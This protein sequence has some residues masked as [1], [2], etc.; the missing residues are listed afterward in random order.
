MP[1]LLFEN[2]AMVGSFSDN[3]KSTI[4]IL[5]SLAAFLTGFT[6]C[7]FHN[8]IFC[9]SRITL[10]TDGKHFLTTV[11]YLVDYLQHYAGTPLANK[12]MHESQMCAHIL[13]DGPVMSLI[14]APVFL[15]LNKIPTPRDWLALAAGQSVLH[16]LS[17]TLVVLAAL[18]MTGSRFFALAAALLFGLYPPAVLQSGHFMSEIPVTTMLLA[19]VFS[20][21]QDKPAFFCRL[22]AGFTAG[23]IIL[24]K[25]ALLPGVVLVCLFVLAKSAP[26]Q[27]QPW[28][29]RLVLSRLAQIYPHLTGFALGLALIVIPWALMSFYSTGSF[30]PTAQRQPVYNVAT[31]WN[32]EAD[33]WGFNPRPP[34]TAMFFDR[35]SPLAVAAGIWISRPQE[36]ALLSISKVSRLASCPWN[37]FKGRAL[38]LDENAQILLHRLIIACA[39]FGAALYFF[40]GRRCLGSRQRLIIEM[41]IIVIVA[42]LSYLMVEC[43]PRYGFTAMPF[44]VLLAV[45]GIW[46]AL[47]LSL[48]DRGSRLSIVISVAGALAFTAFLLNAETLCRLFDRRAFKETAHVLGYMDRLQKIIDLS[49]VKTPE[50]VKSVF[51]MVDGDK[52]LDKC[53][54][55]INGTP[56]KDR[57]IP[58]MHFD[59]QHYNI[60]DQWRE[61][62][63]SMRVSVDDFRQWRAVAI[64]PALI[65][66]HGPNRIVLTN[67]AGNATVYGDRLRTRY[68]LS[69]DYCNYG[70]LSASPLSANAESRYTDPVLT[71]ADRQ[72]SFII[73]ANSPDTTG[74]QSGDSLNNA[75]KTALKDSLRMRLFVT[76][77]DGCPA[78][79]ATP[80]PLK[81]SSKAQPPAKTINVTRESFDRLLWDSGSSDC[82]RINK[83]ILYGARTIAASIPL[84][85]MPGHSHIKLCI[86][87][88]LKAVKTAGEVGLLCVL[89]GENGNVRIL[90]KTP[91]ALSAT[92]EWRTFQIDDLVPL[93]SPFSTAYSL[94][95]AFYPCPWMEGQY[96]VSRRAT[97]AVFRKI[98]ITVISSD[99]PA[100]SGRRIIY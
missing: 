72:E 86:K 7:L 52:S 21:S 51:I 82:I 100:L 98:T 3:P 30:V 33:G 58:A 27:K 32:N 12:F 60:Y 78:T 91:R 53:R 41:A 57:L 20:L 90:G 19:L 48:Q 55:E 59:P 22:S 63:P 4:L 34:F 43:L 80:Q 46:Q 88:Q 97:D 36:S 77:P 8:L 42:H 13:F 79:A 44:A 62:A 64:D 23:V 38:G 28:D 75:T 67:H 81:A 49:L 68:A 47:Q 29:R 50:K 87:G 15:V 69:P 45:Y 92:P 35:E 9:E 99:L 2:K 84:P 56:I 40:C 76:L 94:Q 16:G 83:V 93:S 39:S 37:D 31:G 24:T 11:S 14:Y 74:D 18:R 73:K 65:D 25:P 96:G 1:T 54:L 17:T 5:L 10:A 61:F 70:I 26:E 66:W 71:A 85:A 89:E 6:A 95:M